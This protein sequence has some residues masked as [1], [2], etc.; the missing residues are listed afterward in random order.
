[1]NWYS[2]GLAAASGVIAALVG[3]LIFGK[4]PKKK[5]TYTIVVVILFTLVNTFSKLFILPELDS[6]KAKAEIELVFTEIPAFANI[7]KYEPKIYR[8]LND[9]LT[10]SLKQGFNRQQSIDQ[11]RAEISGLIV[12]RIPHASD[13]AILTYISV[14]VTEM[15]ELDKQGKGLCYKLLF[16]QVGGGIDAH[17]VFT[18]ETQEKD[19]SAF[20]KILKTSST[21][22]EIP[23]ESAVMPLL[24]PLLFNLYNKFGEDVSMLE[25]YT[26]TNVD[27]DKVCGITMHFYKEILTLP[28]EQAASVLRWI[29][30]QA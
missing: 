14:L 11:L 3:R 29:F 17:K 2:I 26:A 9:L 30:S 22:K 8:E 24:E 10:D 21:K 5:I 12:S 18:Q 15:S 6:R 19:L 20:N 27:K 16:P 28:P 1:M 4:K 23:S 25:S 13:E 7:K